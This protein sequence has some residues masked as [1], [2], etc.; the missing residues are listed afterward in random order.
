MSMKSGIALDRGSSIPRPPAF[1][2]SC[3]MSRAW[4][5][6]LDRVRS[7]ARKD[8]MISLVAESRGPFQ[9]VQIGEGLD[10]S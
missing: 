2:G 7:V 6:M 8:F 10:M 3:E 9:L 4:W 1:S 5:G